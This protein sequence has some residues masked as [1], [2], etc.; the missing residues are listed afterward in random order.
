VTGGTSAC[1]FTDASGAVFAAENYDPVAN[2]WKTW[3]NATVVRVYHSTSALLPDGRVLSTGSGDGGGVSQQFT[4]EIFS[5]P[6]LFNG[7]RPTYNLASTTMRYGQ[8]FMVA[9]PN[10]ASITKVTLIRLT[11][12]THAFDG[13]QRLTTLSFVAAADGLS[14]TVAPPADGRKAP[15]GPY[16]LFILNAKG[17][18]SVA[19]T[20]LLS[21]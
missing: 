13:G 5:P 21:Q 14:L 8:A 20:V 17:V 2:T 9:T 1:G 11:S 4:Y 3:A 19:Q 12:T 16:M 10:A 18:P 7:S 15:P 6:Y